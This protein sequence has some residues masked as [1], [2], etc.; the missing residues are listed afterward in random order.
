VEFLRTEAAGGVV[1]LGAT[2]LALV[3]ANLDPTGYADFWHHPVRL[4]IGDWSLDL[5]RHG[6]VNDG[7]MV[8]FFFVV[9]LEIKR[10]LVAGELRDPRTAML[11]VL[12]ALG[13]MLVPAAIYAA[14][15]AGGA[16]SDGWGIPMATDIAFAVGV[17]TLLGSRVSPALKLF[18]LTLAIVDDIGAIVVIAIFYSDGVDLQW[19]AG[20]VMTLVVVVAARRF[21]SSPLA[22]LPLALVLWVC[23]YQSGIH[24]TIAGVVLGLCTPIRSRAG[25]TPLTDLEHRLHPVASFGAVPLFALANAGIVITA[26]AIADALASRVTWGVVTGLVVGKVVGVTLAT[27]LGLRLGIGRLPEGM[28]RREVVGGAALA[29]IGF[30]VSLFIAELSLENALLDQAKLGV[31]GASIVATMLATVVL[32]GRRRRTAR[33]PTPLH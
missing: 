19:L 17:L 15:T 26:T 11:P 2:V 25:T 20:A 13:G 9:G 29:G 24:A 31:L 18:V 7:V 1:L 33:E 12:A 14:W 16:G 10:E 22:Y 30:T 8:V 32:L 5:D 28:S 3:W 4:G 23:T 21:L 27:T 6:W